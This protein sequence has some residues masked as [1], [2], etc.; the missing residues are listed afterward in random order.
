MSVNNFLRDIARY[1]MDFLETDFHKRSVPKR[2]IK[3]RDSNNALVG[4]NL[5]RY[6]SFFKKI[7]NVVNKPLHI[8][9]EI[10][11]Q[12]GQY[13]S[14][15]KANLKDYIDQ[16][17]DS[18]PEELFEQ[19]SNEALEFAISN[20]GSYLED[21]DGFKSSVIENISS[22]L[23]GSL[24]EITVSKLEHIFSSTTKAIDSL[25]RTE[26]ELN[27]LL[28]E[29]LSHSIDQSLNALLIYG[30]PEDLSLVI[31]D[32]HTRLTNMNKKGRIKEK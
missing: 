6:E 4:I 29:D 16:Q 1:Y 27:D 10:S 13:K 18:F 24:I 2:S 20:R 11:I 26:I 23:H 19:M 31:K 8:E 21:P 15:I 17:I 25:Y 3:Y 28:I 7:W 12:K 30:K 9:N 14:K 32:I 22:I 5:Y